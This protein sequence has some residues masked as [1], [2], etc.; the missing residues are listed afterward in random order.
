LLWKSARNLSLR[1]HEYKPAED[2]GGYITRL[3]KYG[4]PQTSPVYS[5]GGKPAPTGHPMRDSAGVRRWNTHYFAPLLSVDIAVGAPIGAENAIPK[6]VD[7]GE[8]TVR[9]KMVNEVE[10]LLAPEP[11]EALET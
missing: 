10:L 5:R 1:S 7:H 8:I 2:C 11:G 9:V 6:E 3:S 4:T